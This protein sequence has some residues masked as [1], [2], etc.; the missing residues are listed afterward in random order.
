MSY[1][2]A[3]LRRD[4]LLAANKGRVEMSVDDVVSVLNEVAS[5]IQSAAN[6]TPPDPPPDGGDGGDTDDITADQA[7]EQAIL[8]NI[9][10]GGA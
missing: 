6:P 10:D 4:A 9:N 1:V 3:D 2:A 7:R 5:D 8:S